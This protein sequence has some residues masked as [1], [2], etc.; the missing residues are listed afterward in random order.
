MKDYEASSPQ[1]KKPPKGGFSASGSLTIRIELTLRRAY[2][3]CLSSGLRSQGGSP[4]E[5]SG[6]L[7]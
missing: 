3:E 5:A 7:P 6:E 4:C 2:N 1:K